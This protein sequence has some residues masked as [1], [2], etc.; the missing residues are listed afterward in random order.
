MFEIS[1]FEKGGLR[2][3]YNMQIVKIPLRLS[4][5]ERERANVWLK[6][7]STINPKNTDFPA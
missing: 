7:T 1:P 4:L 5:C 6:K 2:G 3:I